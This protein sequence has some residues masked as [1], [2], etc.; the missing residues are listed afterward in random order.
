MV[1]EKES[2]HNDLQ[3]CVSCENFF[4]SPIDSDLCIKCDVSQRQLI[5][6]L[7]VGFVFTLGVWLGVNL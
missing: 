3:V 5:G 4:R 2:T 6:L 7:F 1:E